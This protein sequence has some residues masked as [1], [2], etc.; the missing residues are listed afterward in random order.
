MPKRMPQDRRSKVFALRRAGLSWAAIGK[1]VGLSSS[2]VGYILDGGEFL[3]PPA[4][5]TGVALG[6][7]DKPSPCPPGSFP[8]EVRRLRLAA[9]LTLQALADEV[10]VTLTTVWVIEVGEHMPGTAVLVG[11]G[12]AF[13][14]DDAAFG[15]FVRAAAAFDW[16][17]GGSRAVPQETLSQETA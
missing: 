4:P 3:P 6:P 5:R 16:K 15:R 13:A 8:A 2:R 9:G 14:L 11:L 12:R 7:F 1:A 17:V 10:G